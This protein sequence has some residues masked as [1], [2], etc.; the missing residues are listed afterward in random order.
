MS[1][2]VGDGDI[3][4]EMA[5]MIAA[6]VVTTAQILTTEVGEGVPVVTAQA[7]AMAG[8]GGGG[9]AVGS[10]AVL[11]P[12]AGPTA[13]AQ[14]MIRLTQTAVESVD[15]ATVEV[16]SHCPC[17][18]AAAACAA[19]AVPEM[20]YWRSTRW[21]YLM[22]LGA[23][24]SHA[25]WVSLYGDLGLWCAV[26][27]GALT[28]VGAIGF[29][30]VHGHSADWTI[31]GGR[32]HTSRCDFGFALII[33]IGLAAFATASSTNCPAMGTVPANDGACC[34]P[35]LWVHVPQDVVYASLLDGGGTVVTK[36]VNLEVAQHA[37]LQPVP[38]CS[39]TCINATSNTFCED[40]G[41]GS[42]STQ[43]WWTR[44]GDYVPR[45]PLGSDT[46]DCGCR[47]G[48]TLAEWLPPPVEYGWGDRAQAGTCT[49]TLL[50]SAFHFLWCVVIVRVVRQEL[51]QMRNLVGFCCLCCYT[52]IEY[53]LEYEIQ[54]AENRRNRY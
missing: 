25:G 12:E 22:L 10:A 30:F 38:S 7:V 49:S 15:Q 54:A 33:Y 5:P 13:Q 35:A 26:T 51:A 39:D 20:E 28:L 45:C 53:G 40:G 27:G 52:E 36:W 31:N 17:T 6:P 21:F 14:V 43:H 37:G 46:A 1:G 3:Q 41:L 50:I 23:A 47:K 42:Y 34:G 2:V 32:K 8:G 44:I 9:I 19:T 48:T 16:G 29:N 18:A 4:L 11:P 24:V